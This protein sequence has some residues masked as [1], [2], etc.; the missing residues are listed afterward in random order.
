[1]T[2]RHIVRGNGN[3][4]FLAETSSTGDIIFMSK[5]DKYEPVSKEEVFKL[6]DTTIILFEPD[7]SNFKEGSTRQAFFVIDSRMQLHH[8]ISE[9]CKSF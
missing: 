1:M 3:V 6:H 5:S 2:K 8:V 9:D 7:T 4:V